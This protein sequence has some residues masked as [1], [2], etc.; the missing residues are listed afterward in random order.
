MGKVVDIA[1]AGLK[2]DTEALRY[3]AD[4]DSIVQVPPERGGFYFSEWERDFI[5]DM[6][7]VDPIFTPAQREKLK[8]I[9][10][11]VDASER[12]ESDEKSKNLFSKLSP[13]RQAEQRARAA[14]VVLPWEK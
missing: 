2:K 9:W 5:R 12:F 4:L 1:V 7:R 8:E 10:T 14:K 11:K 3:L 6:S 13:E